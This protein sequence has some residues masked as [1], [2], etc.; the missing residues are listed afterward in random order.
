MSIHTSGLTSHSTINLTCIFGY[1]QVD[2]LIFF[3]LNQTVQLSFKKVQ[4]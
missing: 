3:H 2:F 1:E 4:N